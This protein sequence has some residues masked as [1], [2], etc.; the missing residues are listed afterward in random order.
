MILIDTLVRHV[1]MLLRCMCQLAG[2]GLA[3]LCTPRLH[4]PHGC[5]RRRVSW[6]TG[7]SRRRRRVHDSPRAFGSCGYCCPS[8]WIPGRTASI[9]QLR[10]ATSFG[11]QPRYLFRDNDRLFGHGVGAFL[12]SCGIEEVH[13]GITVGAGVLLDPCSQFL[14][15]GGA[16]RDLAALED[17]SRRAIRR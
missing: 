13:T 14:Q 5:L 15:P 4:W 17:L 16:M 12:D 6:V 11:Q 7:S 3:F 9:W 8:C 1:L 10:E 2:C